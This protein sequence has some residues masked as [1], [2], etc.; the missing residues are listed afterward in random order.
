MSKLDSFEK[1]E[2]NES[3]ESVT[4]NENHDDHHDHDLLEGKFDIKDKYTIRRDNIY[5]KAW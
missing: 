2:S 3:V 4:S 5:Y 1:Y